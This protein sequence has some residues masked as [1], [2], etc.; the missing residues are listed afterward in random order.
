[1]SIEVAQASSWSAELRVLPLKQR[2]YRWGRRRQEIFVQLADQLED[3]LTG[4]TAEPASVLDLT[5]AAHVG[6]LTSPV[7]QPNPSM[8]FVVD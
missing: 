6:D 5:E 2:G 1:M 7:V 4:R 8:E 3:L